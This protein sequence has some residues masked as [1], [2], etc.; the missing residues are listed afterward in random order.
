MPADKLTAA[1]AK[2]GAKFI[3]KKAIDVDT[4]KGILAAVL[5]RE[6]DI[7]ALN[8]NT[9]ITITD[10]DGNT[11]T[12]NLLQVH[13]AARKSALQRLAIF[14]ADENEFYKQGANPDDVYL[15]LYEDAIRNFTKQGDISFN[16]PSNK[17]IGG[18]GQGSGQGSGAFSSLGSATNT[19]NTQP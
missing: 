9:P 18:S 14:A 16:I 15:K 4:G 7:T 1:L 10:I 12:S 17:V 6:A 11:T 5:G 8:E 19:I 2:Y 13:Q 3:P